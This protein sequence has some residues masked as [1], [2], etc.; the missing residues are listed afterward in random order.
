[1]VL[2][3]DKITYHT[4][5]DNCI[6]IHHNADDYPVQYLVQRKQEI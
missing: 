1:M 4:A 3:R 5:K 6:Y 2:G